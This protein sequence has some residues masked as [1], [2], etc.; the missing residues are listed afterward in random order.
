[1]AGPRAEDR[2]LMS[3]IA[4]AVE[5]AGKQARAQPSPYPKSGQGLV[6]SDTFSDLPKIGPQEQSKT[7]LCIKYSLLSSY[8]D[9]VKPLIVKLMRVRVPGKAS[10][11]FWAGMGCKVGPK[12][13]YFFCNL[14]GCH[15]EGVALEPPLPWLRTRGVT[16]NPTAPPSP[17]A[18]E[19]RGGVEDLPCVA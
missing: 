3:D 4:K 18:I 1:M 17:P 7:I 9:A 6:S 10:S 16:L 13:P 12:G 19:R 8:Y 15:R 5:A 14:V 11:P 2:L